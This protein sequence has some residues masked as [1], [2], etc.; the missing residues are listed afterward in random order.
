MEPG[1]LKEL[2]DAIIPQLP[3]NDQQALLNA[4]LKFSNVFNNGLGHTS[5]TVHM[6][7]TGDSAPIR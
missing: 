2:E 1:T 4:L 6:I 7:D 3:P 5:I